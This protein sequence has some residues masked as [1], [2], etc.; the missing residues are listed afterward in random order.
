MQVVL[1]GCALE[2]DFGGPF[3]EPDATTAPEARDGYDTDILSQAAA[4]AALSARD[5]AR[6]SWKR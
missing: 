6:E 5:E 2:R 3:D 4:T 1:G